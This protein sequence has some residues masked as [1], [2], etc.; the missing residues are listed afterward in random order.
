MVYEALTKSAS[1]TPVAT[2]GNATT[3]LSPGAE[4]L[5]E[6]AQIQTNTPNAPPTSARIFTLIIAVQM[7]NSTQDCRSC[8]FW[9]V[10]LH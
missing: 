5:S 8:P 4:P 2:R 6:Q 10:C 9:R 3:P 7:G 1:V